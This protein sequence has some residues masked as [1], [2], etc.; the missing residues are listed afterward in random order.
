MAIVSIVLFAGLYS[1]EKEQS[2]ESGI[3][4]PADTTG[5][6]GNNVTGDFRAKING[7]QWVADRAAQAYRVGGLIN[8]AGIS[9]DQKLITITLRDSGVHQYSIDFNSAAHAV[10][11]VDSTLPDKDAF[12]TNQGS[13]ALQSGGTLT[14]TSIDEVNKTMSG[15]FS[16]LVWRLSDGTQRTISEGSFTNI[17]Y[18]TTLPPANASDDF[19]VKID[20]TLFTAASIFGFGGGAGFNNIAI[21]GSDAVGSKTVALYFPTDVTPGTYNMG[22]ILDSYYAQYN[23]NSSTFLVS[24]TGTLTIL[25]HNIATKRVTGTFSFTA[26]PFGGAGSAAVLTEGSFA[27]TYQ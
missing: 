15:T 3:T 11:L 16:F 22:T 23:V 17:S 24:T 12:T 9:T 6:G 13:S 19:K 27:A 1:C 18:N 21:S 2:F 20:G 7:N 14:I 26:T 10:A 8:I 4:P 25:T 5:T